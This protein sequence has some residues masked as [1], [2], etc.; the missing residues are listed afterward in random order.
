M[1][2]IG[3]KYQR[4]LNKE[5]QKYPEILLAW[6]YTKHKIMQLYANTK[7]IHRNLMLCNDVM[8][9]SSETR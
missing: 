3:W 8:A 1:G 7:A 6:Q 4:L 5:H 2:S 9:K